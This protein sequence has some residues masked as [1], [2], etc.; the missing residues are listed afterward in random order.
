MKKGIKLE[1][2]QNESREKPKIFA[3]VRIRMRVEKCKTKKWRVEK[4]KDNEE[5]NKTRIEA[6]RKPRETENFHQNADSNA[7]EKMPSYEMT[8]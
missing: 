2:K 3:K 1:S 5:F 8:S 6:E 7:C 4:T